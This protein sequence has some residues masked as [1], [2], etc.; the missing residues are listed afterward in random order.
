MGNRDVKIDMGNDTL[1]IKMGN[2]TT[3]LDLGK[4]ETEAMQSIE[5]KVGQ[6]SIKVDQMGVTIKGMMIKVEGQIMTAGEGPDDPGQ[7]HRDPP[8]QGRPDDDR[9]TELRALARAR[10]GTRLTPAVGRPLLDSEHEDRS[11][12]SQEAMVH[13]SAERAAEALRTVRRPVRRPRACSATDQTPG[14]SS[15]SLIEKRR[16]PRRG[17]VPGVR[18]AEARGRLVGLRLCARMAAGANPPAP[19]LAALHAAEAWVSRPDRGEPPRGDARRGGRPGS[20]PPAGCAAVSAFWSGGSLAPPNVPVV[21]P[22]ET[23][24]AHG[25]AGSV[26]L[27]AVASEPEKAPEKFRSFLERGIGRRRGDVR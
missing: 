25:V 1:T 18:P 11:S 17:P 5:L 12:M 16:I 27:A 3:K 23:L 9:L 14:N 8:G 6:S 2:Q 15:T 24:T 10:T 19:I 26:M 13:V 4:S 7:R 22:G 20:R 21:P